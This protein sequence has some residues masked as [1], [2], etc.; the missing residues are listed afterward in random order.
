MFNS[1]K[2]RCLRHV[3]W[4]EEGSLLNKCI[5]EMLEKG[6]VEKDRKTRGWETGRNIWERWGTEFGERK[7]RTQMNGQLKP[8]MGCDSNDFK[9]GDD[10]F[11][12]VIPVYKA[13]NGWGED[14]LTTRHHETCWMI[15]CFCLQR[16]GS[17]TDCQAVWWWLW[18]LLLIHLCYISSPFW[19]DLQ[20]QY[21]CL[22]RNGVNIK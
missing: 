17:E 6:R 10:R 11:V 18:W 9:Y 4:R 22:F 2:I 3:E 13:N 1:L 14:L 12:A 20:Q 5:E 8:V 16:S 15:V 19:F 21:R 7:H